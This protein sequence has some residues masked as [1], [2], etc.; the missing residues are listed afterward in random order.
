MPL[1]K[2]LTASQGLGPSGPPCKRHVYYRAHSRSD[3]SKPAA[4][5]DSNSDG[6]HLIHTLIVHQRWR[7]YKAA[8]V[9]F[10][11]KCTDWRGRGGGEGER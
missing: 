9:Y 8:A 1:Y 3:V 6:A 7:L 4:E 2:H 5:W 11:K 10:S